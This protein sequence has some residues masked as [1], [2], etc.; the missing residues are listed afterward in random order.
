M[1]KSC[2]LQMITCHGRT[3]LCA[4]CNSASRSAKLVSPLVDLSLFCSYTCSCILTSSSLC[5]CLHHATVSPATSIM[6]MSLLQSQLYNL[7][8]LSEPKNVYILLSLRSTDTPSLSLS[9]THVFVSLCPPRTIRSTP[10]R[11]MRCR[12]SV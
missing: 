11:H 7:N 1:Y 8:Y 3:S 4:I 5:C 2:T 9:S 6:Q 10:A 12:R